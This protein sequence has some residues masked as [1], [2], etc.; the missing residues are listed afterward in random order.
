VGQPRAGALEAF[1]E[2]VGCQV[3]WT[4]AR[5]HDELVARI[6]HFPHLMAAATA[7]VSLRDSADARFGGG[8]LRDTTRVAGGDATMWAEILIENRKAVAKA[9]EETREGL[10]E[11]LAMLES[12][13]HEAVRSWLERARL[14]HQA[15]RPRR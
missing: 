15:A 3:S 12:G 9:V 4:D 6:S 5:R 13:D 1:W 14:L 8:G 2:A 7:R 11:M 10:G